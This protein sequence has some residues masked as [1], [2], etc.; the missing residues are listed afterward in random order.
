MEFALAERVVAALAVVGLVLLGLQ[1]LVRAGL[2]RALLPGSRG[3]VI[4]I[5]ETA[6]LPGAA[7]LHVVEIAGRRYVVGRG[8]GSL[9]ML[10]E[11]PPESSRLEAVS[12]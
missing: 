6:T 1:T 3:R 7:T 5:L 10:C 2:R 8:G 11:I 4:T 9:S 12:G